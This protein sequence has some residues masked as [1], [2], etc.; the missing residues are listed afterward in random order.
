M[1][2]LIRVYWDA[3]TWIAYIAQEKSI[4][5]SDGS[6]ENRFAMCSEIMKQAQN[7]QLEIVT[8][9]FTLAEVCKAPTVKDSPADNLSAFFE[10]SYILTVPVDLSIGKNA[11]NMQA[12]G[13]VNLKPPD[14]VHLASARR[15]AVSEIHTFD[16]KI[17]KFDG[18]I[19]GID[20]KPMK[21]CKPT[22]G[23]PLGP[24]FD[25]KSDADSKPD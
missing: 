24:L 2:K 20:G 4:A 15:A 23:T 10:K 6:I 14:A 17:L 8:S 11:Q 13:L 1:A 9:A 25:E 22:E 18:D 21:I 12:S 3:C 19:A 7:G 16:E 5:K